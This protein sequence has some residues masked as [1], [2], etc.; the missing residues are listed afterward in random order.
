MPI[1]MIIMLLNLGLAWNA[2][3]ARR[4]QGTDG[5][6][7]DGILDACARTS[8]VVLVSLLGLLALGVMYGNV[9]GMKPT[10]P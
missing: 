5:V 8:V 9:L 3:M 10:A 1:L 4:R 2:G 6:D 7:E